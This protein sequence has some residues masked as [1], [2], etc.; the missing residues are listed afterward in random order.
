VNDQARTNGELI[1]EL[2]VLKQRIQE[3]EQSESERKR[4]EEAVRLSEQQLKSYIENAGDAI[5]V[6]KVDTGRI[7]NCNSRACLDLGYSRDEIVKLSS[8]DIESNLSSGEIDT[9]HHDLKPGE[10]KTV[11]GTHKR[12][13][14]SVFPIEIR[15]SLLSPAQP[16]LII[17]IARDITERK[18]AEEEGRRSQKAA[19]R[20]AEEMAIIAEIGRVIG[21]TLN[22]QEVYD[23]FSEEVQRLISFDR[24]SVVTNI[25]PTEGTYKI[26]YVNGIDIPGRK[27]GDLIPLRRS[28]CEIIMKTR[29]GM[30]NNLADIEDM[31][32]RFPSVTRNF[33]I[34]VGLISMISVPLMSRDEVIGILHLRSSKPNAYTEEDLRLTSRIGEQIS[35]AIV[36]AQ[37]YDELRNTRDTLEVQVRERT[38]ELEETNT[39][40]RVL[41]KNEDKDQKRLEESLQSNINQLVTPFLSKLRVS[42]SNPERLTY[43]N[44]LEANLDNIVSPFINRLSAAYKNLTPKE[45]Q[46]AELVKQGKRS[47]EI[48]ELFGICVGTV[49]AHRNKIRKKLGLKSKSANLR[50]HL[51][52]MR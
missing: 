5:Y 31:S 28:F 10:V 20:L 4:A 45:I 18:R 40:L 17:A 47:K 34:K 52:S 7:L 22:I 12:K 37:L 30:V 42:K 16:E 13:D 36:N 21:S 3:L 50:S 14:G 43:L 11:E 19:E 51:L 41:L 46:I 44:I 2:S 27:P 9:I 8:T 35:G 6:L 32:R 15:F 39:A 38:I 49:I 24:L 48:A 25:N 33:A 26:S 1:E 23:R 29:K